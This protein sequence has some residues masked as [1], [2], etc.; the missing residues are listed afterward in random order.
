MLFLKG[1]ALKKSY[2]DRDILINESLAI[3]NH[4][5]IGLVGK[6]GEG[7]STLLS[8]LAGIQEPDSGHIERCGTVAYIPQI[9]ETEQ[10]ISALLA[11]KWQLPD[12]EQEVISGGEHTR[13]KIA[14]ALTSNANVLIADEPTSHLDVVGIEQL[15]ENLQSFRGALLLTSHDKAFLNKLCTK[16][17][18]IEQGKLTEY[19]GNY[20][21]YM[22]QKEKKKE[23]EYKEYEEYV[24]EKNRL[25][26]AA[27][28][29]QVKSHS[30]KK[31]PSRMGNSEARLH[32]RSS[33]DMKAKLNRSVQ[34][35]GT[36][37]EKLEKKEKPKEEEAIVFDI[38]D[39]PALHS[40]RAIQF[41]GCS[42][43]IGPTL[44]KEHIYGDV[45]TKSRLAIIGENG[46]GK[47]TLLN[48]MV[49]RQTDISVAKPAKIGFFAQHQENLIETKTILENISEDSP[50][51]QSFI[52]TVLSRLAFKRE[53]V[54]KQVSVLSGGERVRASLAKVFLGNYNVLMLDEPTNYLDIHTKEALI[55]VL[56]A[57]PG[58]I[59]FVTHDRSLVKSLATHT[60]S[61]D[62]DNPRVRAV[63]QQ[64]SNKD[65][66]TEVQ[67]QE[68]ELLAIEVQI[69]DV[70][71]K[72]STAVNEEEKQVLDKKFQELL[73]KKK[74]LTKNT[75]I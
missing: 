30:L 13:R 16:I 72:L 9:E 24:H 73:K 48:K 14:A 5:C 8:I 55:E 44:L 23:K 1:K 12:E 67:H 3:Y 15:E 32:K 62:D 59:V 29:L 49:E 20:D 75:L 66:S 27:Q 38:A 51:N 69:I 70:L 21:E 74:Q 60:L 39:F 18:E 61:F 45:P 10:E 65:K 56:K 11:S 25:T 47:T 36:R 54:H 7:K 50:Y 19:E 31:A 35:M 41:N 57:Y 42:L 58:T 28:N 37:I 71:G 46:S 34:A 6:N 17:W 2:G 63:T 33:E 64:P 43:K 4:D 22:K 26:K 52:R 68:D 40:K 53:D